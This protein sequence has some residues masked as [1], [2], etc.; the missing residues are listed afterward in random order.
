MN[1]SSSSET[2]PELIT[3]AL[4]AA[5]VQEAAAAQAAAAATTTPTRTATTSSSSSKTT[6]SGFS[7]DA[8]L[9]ACGVGDEQ[10]IA[11]LQ[12]KCFCS[13][14]SEIGC[15]TKQFKTATTRTYLNDGAMEVIVGRAEAEN[16]HRGNFTALA[17]KVHRR[18]R[19]KGSNNRQLKHATAQ[20][21]T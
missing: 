16:G 8:S 6:K 14:K 5:A 12:K 21:T 10:I 13:M 4:T 19:D 7:V 3:G 2:T 20:T 1:S 17:T 9:D 15:K 18:R 11:D